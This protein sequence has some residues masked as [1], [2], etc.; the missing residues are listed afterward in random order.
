MTFGTDQKRHL[1]R[2]FRRSWTHERPQNVGVWIRDEMQGVKYKP[3][4]CRTVREYIDD[5]VKKPIHSILGMATRPGGMETTT[6]IHHLYLLLDRGSGGVKKLF[7]HTKRQRKGVEPIADPPVGK[8]ALPE[9]GHLRADWDNLV[10]NRR[11]TRCE[12]YNYYFRAAMEVNVPEGKRIVID[13]APE[14]KIHVRDFDE[15]HFATV[16]QNATEKLQAPPGNYVMSSREILA[17]PTMSAPTVRV[18]KGALDPN[19]YTHNISEGDLSA[20]FHINKHIPHTNNPHC[21]PGETILIDS[22]DG[23]SL[24]IALLHAR[25]RVDPVTNRFN[26]RVWVYL[27]G[28]PRS[29]ESHKRRAEVERKKIAACD[30]ELEAL[31][32]MAPAKKREAIE[33][34]KAKA[35]A[36]LK[37]ILED[38][39]DGRDVYVNINKLYLL[40]EQHPQLSLAQYPQGMAVLLYMLSG[41]DFFDDF[42]G[43]EWGLF[44]NM[45]WEE[46]VWDTWCRHADRFR[47]MLLMTYYGPTCYGQ[48]EL[49]RHPFI[50]EDCMLN[51]IYQCY[52]AKY[53][54]TIRKKKNLGAKNKL[55]VAML[56]EHTQMFVTNCVRK[57][58]ETDEA[59][60]K[61]LKLAK[62]KRL[63]NRGILRRYIRL[64]VYALGYSINDYRPGGS[65]AID[66]LELYEGYPYYGFIRDPEDP[67]RLTL[68]EVC[69][70]PK[71]IPEHF[72]DF[73]NRHLRQYEQQHKVSLNDNNND[74]DH[75]QLEDHH[76]QSNVKREQQGE[77]EEEEEE[78][79][80]RLL[81]RKR[82]RD[83]EEEE[84]LQREREERQRKLEEK[85]KR[86]RQRAADGE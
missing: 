14:T 33:K 57:N 72:A 42:Y 32:K 38:P 60:E 19:L 31:P 81:L 1:L 20:F 28:D 69:S 30:A 58:N 12:L 2:I 9:E 77:E 13:G 35:E 65:Q 76:H 66:P 83:A 45:G 36:E 48:P 46:F 44:V 37:D 15:K 71:P 49:I 6:S 3:P 55:T 80:L 52:G 18:V 47:Y 73:V 17:T 5:H 84:G 11:V 23:D 39:V 64:A 16:Y 27:P 21:P 78:A 70:M 29:V 26:S 51:F 7:A 79:R 50:D 61:R 40:I 34:K 24:M 63:P 85:Q 86:Q 8:F 43:D 75:H 22:N 54:D 59:Y 53:G 56:E 25:D 68:A 10:A 82:E 74:G 41:S 4:T 67:N 62:R